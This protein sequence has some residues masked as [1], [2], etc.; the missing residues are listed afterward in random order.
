MAA[1]TLPCSRNGAPQVCQAGSGAVVTSIAIDDRR[2]RQRC[3]PPLRDNH[4]SEDQEEEHP[5][6]SKPTPNAEEGRHNDTPPL[7]RAVVYCGDTKGNIRCF[8]EEGPRFGSRNSKV[9]FEER[10]V[11]DE[12]GRDRAAIDKEGVRPCSVLKRQHGNNQVRGDFSTAHFYRKDYPSVDRLV[13]ASDAGVGCVSVIS[14]RS[15]LQ[16]S[17]KVPSPSV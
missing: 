9:C 10:G 11:V 16:A 12:G 1:D 14:P 8:L 13:V 2:R 6:G 3:S 17:C 15:K 5:I 4:C 7:A